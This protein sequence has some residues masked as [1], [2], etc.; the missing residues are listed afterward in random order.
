MVQAHS[1]T[2]GAARSQAIL[3]LIFYALAYLGLFIWLLVI[4]LVLSRGAIFSSPLALI[5]IMLVPPIISPL[6]VAYA[7]T[8][9][10]ATVHN[11][12][13]REALNYWTLAVFGP[14]IPFK[15]YETL[16]V[17]H[18]E[19]E[20]K[21]R[22]LLVYRLGGPGIL[23]VF[24]DSAVVLEYDGCLTRIAG[25]HVGFLRPFEQVRETIDLRPQVREVVAKVVTKDGFMVEAD[26]RLTFQIEMDPNAP[27][28]DQVPYTP[29]P[30]ALKRAMLGQTN[31]NKERVMNWAD[32]V[33]G[34]ID[35]TL[36]GIV[37]DY[38]LD[39][40]FTDPNIRS[41]IQTEMRNR[42]TRIAHNFGARPLDLQLS[43]FRLS[44][45][46]LNLRVQDQRVEVWK[47][48][49][50]GQAA[51]ER[52]RGDAE[53][54]ALRAQAELEVRK[55]MLQEL[56]NCLKPVDPTVTRRLIAL[57]MV[58]TLEKMS[59]SPESGIFIPRE[60][61]ETLEKLRELLK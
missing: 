3:H 23:V 6:L 20:K 2:K 5:L 45:Q 42:L 52:A 47:A 11:L 9:F 51:V 49:R 4:T 37:S 38:T 12:P 17:Q 34:N 35:S 54:L 10:V 27:V 8:R 40:L 18:G 24:S 53:A 60:T 14:P 1:L 19:I 22:N 50:E 44:H 55:M 58:E 59:T 43:A 26:V 57:R 29:D 30:D 36:R 61:A 39:E 15:D 7:A 46:E 48:G 32:R 13:T 41:T 28:T 25:P 21:D 31:F 16:T 33:A 56:T